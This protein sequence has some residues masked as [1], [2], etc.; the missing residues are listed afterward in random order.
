MQFSFDISV[1]MHFQ[2]FSMPVAVSDNYRAVAIGSLVMKLF[3]YVMLIL[4]SD[5]LTTDELQFG[6]ESMSSSVMCTWGISTIVEYFNRQGRDVYACSMD[7]SKA[8]D[9]VEWVGVGHRVL[10]TPDP[11]RS[12]KLSNIRLR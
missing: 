4:E 5:K 8:F 3:D 1:T 2:K 12:Q 9:M 7:L 11:V 10:D 6:Y